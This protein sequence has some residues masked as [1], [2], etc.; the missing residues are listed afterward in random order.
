MAFLAKSNEGVITKK[1]EAMVEK[2]EDEEL[3]IERQERR[4]FQEIEK[5]FFCKKKKMNQQD[6]YDLL[7][8]DFQQIILMSKGLGGK[9]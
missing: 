7:L 2:H 1:K 9:R 4:K 3:K 8:C 6:K 5:H